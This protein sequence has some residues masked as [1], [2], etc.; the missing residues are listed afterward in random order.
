LSCG[1]TEM[2]NLVNKS[3]PQEAPTAETC[4]EAEIAIA[5]DYSMFTYMGSSAALQTRI[6]DIL[7]AVNVYYADPSVM[8]SFRL[9]TL[10]IAASAAQDTWTTSTDFNALLSSFAAWGQAGGFGAAVYDVAT[11]WT[12]RASNLGDARVGQAQLGAVCPK[13]YNVCQHWVSPAPGRP[14]VFFPSMIQAH[15]LGHNFSA[16]HASGPPYIMAPLMN[17]TCIQWDPAAISAITSFK[18][19]SS[20]LSACS[21]NSV[22]EITSKP[23]A[24]MFLYPNPTQGICELKPI[25]GIGKQIH[26]NVINIIGEVVYTLEAE[27]TT[28]VKRLDLSDLPYGIYTVIMKEGEE[29]YYQKLIVI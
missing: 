28:G 20:C 12:F 7:N 2:H 21:G 23:S 19:N 22:N 6:T 8:I 27:S 10:F 13:G 29:N 9:T 5:T 1:V 17:A 24:E 11:L 26:L 18:Q 3:L 4:K 14:P 25:H 15:E 16:N